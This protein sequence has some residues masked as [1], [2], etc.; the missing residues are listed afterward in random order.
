MMPLLIRQSSCVSHW[1]L[2]VTGQLSRRR[3]ASAWLAM[4]AERPLGGGDTAGQTLR[5][6]GGRARP[7]GGDWRDGRR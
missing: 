2:P 6:T 3:E 5:A 7:K 4:A 1:R